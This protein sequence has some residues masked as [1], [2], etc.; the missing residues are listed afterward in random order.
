MIPIPL[1]PIKDVIRKFVIFYKLNPAFVVFENGID[2]DEV[3]MKTS[4]TFGIAPQFL[5][6]MEKVR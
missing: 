3:L 6:V 4:R 2:S 1:N 5:E